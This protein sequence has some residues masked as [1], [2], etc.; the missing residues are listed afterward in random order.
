MQT[1]WKITSIKA[2]KCLETNKVALIC[3]FFLGQK[4]FFLIRRIYIYL[5]KATP[6]KS[7]RYIFEQNCSLSYVLKGVQKSCRL[8][9]HGMK[10]SPF[11]TIRKLFIWSFVWSGFHSNWLIHS[12]FS[13]YVQVITFSISASLRFEMTVYF[14][15]KSIFS[16]FF[17]G[18]FIKKSKFT[19]L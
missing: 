4:K 15:L 10:N 2:K 12:E 18:T 5:K 1:G 9:I 6:K 8:S 3:D 16:F 7:I 14:S 17:K 13:V 19:Y 11:L